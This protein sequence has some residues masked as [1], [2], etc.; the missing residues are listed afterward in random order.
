MAIVLVRLASCHCQ[1]TSLRNC[2]VLNDLIKF[3]SIE[4]EELEAVIVASSAYRSNS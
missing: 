1:H 4:R 3:K 2:E